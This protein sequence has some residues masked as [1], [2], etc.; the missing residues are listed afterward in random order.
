MPPRRPA[1]GHQHAAHPAR[2]QQPVEGMWLLGVVIDQQ[3]ALPPPQDLEQVADHRLLIGD[4]R[5]AQPSTQPSERR[6]RAGRLLGINPPDQVV[7]AAVAVGEL[8]DELGLAHPT[9]TVHGLHRQHRCDR[10]LRQALPQLL[11][12]CGSAGEGE[13]ACGQVADRGHP[14][15]KCRTSP[16]AAVGR[17]PWERGGGWASIGRAHPFEQPGP[18]GVLVTADE[19]DIDAAAQQPRRRPRLDPDRDQQP[20]LSGRVPDERRP[21]LRLAELRT[22]VRSRQH[23][24]RPYRARGRALHLTD[25]VLTRTDV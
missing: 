10:R 25:E 11:Q 17:A 14:P 1:G 9:Q 8:R 13:V 4:D 16:V 12:Q 6:G 21:P 3:P 23:R 7:V 22:R 19:I 2:G 15:R 18:R 24:D 20:M 5:N